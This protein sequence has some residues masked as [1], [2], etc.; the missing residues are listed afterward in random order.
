MALSLAQRHRLK[1]LASQEAAAASPA[2]S[3]AGGTAYEMQLAQL[4]QH[5]LRLKQ[6]QSN[7]GK[8]ALK[9]Q[10]LPEYVPYVDGVLAAGNGA[11]D[12]VLTTIMIWRIDA[13][14]YT[15]ALDIA[16]YVLQHNLLMPDRFERTTGC[17]VAEEIAEG[18]LISQ[19]ASGGFDLAVLHRTM[20]LTAEQ[21]MPDEVRA[22]LYLATGRATVAGLT[23]DNPGQ[24]GKVMAGI[25]LL[26]RAI[27]LN[28]SC[29]GKK[30]LEGAE[31]LLKKIASPTG[32]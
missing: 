7:E 24:P 12:E 11:Q 14:D 21:D 5:R 25:E 28:G 3:M 4:L 31:R 8:A 9:L 32:S 19:K 29:G 30:D 17:L 2:V 15:G 26:K 22:K 10:L 20:E 16:A 6:I 1:A 13:G 18:A 23:A 27:E